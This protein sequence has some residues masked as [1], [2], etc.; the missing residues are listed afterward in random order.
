MTIFNVLVKEV[1]YGNIEVEA[2][3]KEEA[4]KEALSKLHEADWCDADYT[5]EEVKK[6]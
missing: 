6:K 4:E 2:D 5:I 1:V 3:N